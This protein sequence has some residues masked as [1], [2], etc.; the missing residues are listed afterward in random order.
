MCVCTCVVCLTRLQATWEQHR[1][2]PS[3]YIFPE[4]TMQKTNKQPCGL[5]VGTHEI[6]IQW[7]N[8]SITPFP[9]TLNLALSASIWISFSLGLPS[10]LPFMFWISARNLQESPLPSTFYL[11]CL[12]LSMAS[13]PEDLYHG[14]TCSTPYGSDS[15]W[16]VCALLGQVWV[17]LGTRYKEEHVYLLMCWF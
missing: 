13:P 2:S 6:R 8:E 17:I 9:N 7:M 15:P 5:K 16:V 3:W 10:K 12:P 1:L 14:P 11:F 4:P